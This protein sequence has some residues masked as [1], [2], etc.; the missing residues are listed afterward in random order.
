MQMEGDLLLRN[1]SAFCVFISYLQVIIIRWNHYHLVKC[2]ATSVLYGF[3]SKCYIL[4]V[5]WRIQS[6][7]LTTMVKVRQLEQ[8]VTEHQVHWWMVTPMMMLS[9]AAAMW[10]PFCWLRKEGPNKG[11]FN[12]Y[13]VSSPPLHACITVR[14][15]W[16]TSWVSKNV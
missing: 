1:V 3:A 7:S 8:A 6:Q 13:I 12:R 14:A 11:L 2:V 10:M 15:E 9:Y 5:S 16:Q 4:P